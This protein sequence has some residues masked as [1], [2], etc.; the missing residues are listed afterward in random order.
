MIKLYLKQ[1]WT[2]IKQNKLFTSIY[3]VGTGLSIALTMTMFI[4]FYVKFAPIYPEYN[5]D[6]MLTI[7]A[8][9]CYPK[10]NKES[11]NCNG[12]ASYYLV[13]KMLKDLPHLEAIGAGTQDFMGNN[14][15]ALPDKKEVMEVNPYYADSGFWSVFS[16]RFLTGKP[17]TQ[18]DVDA[19][20]PV[21]V[22]SESLAKR[23]FA[24]TDVVG[25]YFTFNG[26]EFR[27]C[28]VVQDVSNATP[29][30]AGDLWIPL[31]LHSWVSRT[32]EGEKLIGNVQIYMLAPTP[33]DK[34]AL[35][36]E[37]QDVFRK[38]NLQT[39]E[40]ENDLMQQPDD[41]W[42]STFRKNSC[43]APDWGE[44]LKGL[45]YILLALLFIPAMNLSG[46]IYRVWIIA[47]VSWGYAGRMEP[48]IKYCWDR[49]YGKICY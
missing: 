28:G 45:I 29:D 44:L 10:T 34:E 13:D 8:M 12:G 47:C 11:W 36:A 2:L 14:T 5:R 27:V 22:L 4:I 48:P 49:C 21:A 46:M 3:V 43:E 19:G 24:S 30:T 40:Y 41:F 6:R 23:I 18:A 17:F 32:F 25:K 31:F 20:L 7:K 33:A 26:K 38:Y 39:S 1:A 9:K 42:K 16:F 37:V 35:R 15:I